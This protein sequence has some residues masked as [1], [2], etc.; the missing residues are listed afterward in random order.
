MPLQE[1]RHL[2]EG[3]VWLIDQPV[4][5]LDSLTPVRG[6]LQ[7]TH[8]GNMLEVEGKAET[9][10]T[11]CCDRCLQHFNRPLRAADKELL[12]IGE[13]VEDPGKPVDLEG[14]GEE[15]ELMEQLDPRGSFD[16]EHWIFQQLQ[17][18][19]PIVNHCGKHC[20]GPATWSS[21]SSGVDPRWRALQDMNP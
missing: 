16:P 10:V 7:A 14:A 5:G 12:W 19:L 8:R 1:L 6:H 21:D 2:E 20:P 11:L 17:L 3:R 4:D 9:I 18:Q 13:P 15:P